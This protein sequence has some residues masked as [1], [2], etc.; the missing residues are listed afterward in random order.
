MVVLVVIVVPNTLQGDAKP[1]GRSVMVVGN[2]TISSQCADPGIDLSQSKGNNLHATNK[3]HGSKQNQNQSQNRSHHDFYEVNNQDNFKFDYEQDSITIVFNTQFRNKIVIFDEISSQPSLQ[4][5]LT[6]LHVS[7]A[8]N[9]K[10]F[11]FK[12]DTGVCGNLLPYNLY[13][14]DCRTQGSY[15]L[16]V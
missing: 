4:C 10:I 9:G 1:L 12:V 13:K 2:L 14:P 3:P 7:D 16:S 15:E 6:D 5:A 11:C 8:S